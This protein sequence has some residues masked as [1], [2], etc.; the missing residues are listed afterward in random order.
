MSGNSTSTTPDPGRPVG[1]RRR[2]L[3]LNVDGAASPAGMP[4]NHLL[5]TEG[6]RSRQ[7]L[8]RQS[9]C[10]STGRRIRKGRGGE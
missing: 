8:V 5:V 3:G 2:R 1:E 7:L 9:P 10:T 6:G 4:A